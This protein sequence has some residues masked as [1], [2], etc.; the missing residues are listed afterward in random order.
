VSLKDGIHDPEGQA[1]ASALG[2]MGF[3]EV[4]DVRIGKI[5]EIELED[6]TADADGR[7][8]QMCEQILSNPVIEKFHIQTEQS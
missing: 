1:V 4:K 6:G 5:I 8:Q 7:I 2:R 3:A